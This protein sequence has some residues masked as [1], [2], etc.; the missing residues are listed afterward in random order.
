MSCLN[1]PGAIFAGIHD[2]GS[3]KGLASTVRRDIPEDT[4]IVDL[5]TGDID[6][7]GD[8]FE[9][10]KDCWDIIPSQIRSLLVEEIEALCQDGNIEPGQEPTGAEIEAA[11]DMADVSFAPI[12]DEND[13]PGFVPEG[14]AAEET[15]QP[16]QPLWRNLRW[17]R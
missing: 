12:F 14:A 7:N 2:D 10:L 11:L 16:M 15:G 13:L 17:G 9:I 4:F 8:R 1:F 3:T 5:D 6:C